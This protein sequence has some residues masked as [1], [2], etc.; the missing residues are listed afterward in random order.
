MA[1]SVNGAG[2]YTYAFGVQATIDGGSGYL[3][4]S[5]TENTQA[6]TAEGR[7][8]NGDVAVVTTYNEREEISYE[9]I[10]P[11][12]AAN[13]PATGSIFTRGGKSYIITAST[14]SESNSDF[15][16]YSVTAMRYTA[17]GIPTTSSS[18]NG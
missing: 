7:D 17:N 1:E 15:V 14:K 4:Q 18:S 2:G 3:I 13:P 12:S 6:D 16:R 11:V 5:W 9:A 8:G 10:V